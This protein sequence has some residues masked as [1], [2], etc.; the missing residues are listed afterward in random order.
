MQQQPQ[1]TQGQST[2]QQGA[3]TGGSTREGGQALQPVG[4]GTQQS[5]FA[6]PGV[7]PQTQMGGIQQGQPQAGQQIAQGPQQFQQGSMGLALRDVE[8]PEQRA[9]VD[10][11][12]RAIQV[13]GWCADQCIQTADATMIE[14]IRLC[15]DVAELGETVLSLAPRNS[16]YL[17]PVLRAFEQAAQACAQECGQHSHAHCQECAQVLPQAA[18]AVQQFQAG[19]G[20]QRQTG[21]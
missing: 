14:C 10:N 4:Q 13:C 21:V 12:A 16:R 1:P 15:H 19:L 8:T 5:Q 20:Q 6:Q 2:H 17:Q 18:Q 11:V 9:A 7:Q 3:T